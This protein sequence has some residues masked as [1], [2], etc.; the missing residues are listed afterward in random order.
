MNTAENSVVKG[1]F[2][3]NIVAWLVDLKSVIVFF[4]NDYNRGL[5][6]ALSVN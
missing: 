5:V 2:T 4:P 1:V 6:F 3:E